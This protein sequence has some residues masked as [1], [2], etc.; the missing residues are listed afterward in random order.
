MGKQRETLSQQ[1]RRAIL[2]APITR[3]RMAKELG[4]HASTLSRFVNGERGLPLELIDRLGELLGLRLMVDGAPADESGT[5]ENAGSKGRVR[6]KSPGKA[7]DK[8]RKGDSPVGDRSKASK[9]NK[10]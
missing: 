8:V 4:I 10:S 2:E 1:L 7:R 5:Q 9:G 3:Y 6:E